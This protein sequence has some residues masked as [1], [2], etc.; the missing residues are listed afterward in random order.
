MTITLM[1][2]VSYGKTSSERSL[3]KN[4]APNRDAIKPSLAREI[5][6]WR[7]AHG[8]SR[9]AARA[10]CIADFRWLSSAG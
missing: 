2:A 10:V 5:G 3:K 1:R 4:P 8:N 6:L 9:P 7:K